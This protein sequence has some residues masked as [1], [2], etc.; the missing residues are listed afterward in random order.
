MANGNQGI[1]DQI[2]A[3]KWIKQNINV[4]GGDLNNI[5]IFG[6]SAGA[7]SGHILAISPLSKGNIFSRE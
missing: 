7:I 3:L 5:T 4:F 2:A 1:K 6:N